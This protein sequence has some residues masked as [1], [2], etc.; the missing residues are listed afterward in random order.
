[1]TSAAKQSRR[2]LH[3]RMQRD[4]HGMETCPEQPPLGLQP[5]RMC[6]SCR[7]SGW[8]KSD[9]DNLFYLCPCAIPT[10]KFELHA[11]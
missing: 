5:E 9:T 1:M 3:E 10:H 4:T 6:L 11:W 2:E 8:K 7:G